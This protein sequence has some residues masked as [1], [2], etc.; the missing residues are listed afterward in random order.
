MRKS[1]EL[2]QGFKE[3]AG[4]LPQ[5]DFARYL[6]QTFDEQTAREVLKIFQQIELPAPE[7]EQEFLPGTEGCIAFLSRCG[8]SIRIEYKDMANSPSAHAAD[9]INDS[10]FIIRPLASIDAGKATIEI[11]PGCH[12]SDDG[13][14]SFRLSMQLH[15]L[16]INFWDEGPQNIGIIPV[17]TP[18]FPDGITVVIDRG[19]VNRL[20]TS[21]AQV[22][23]ALASAEASAAEEAEQELYAPLCQSFVE[24]WEGRQTMQ[25]FWDLCRIYAREGK[26]V[27]GWNEGEAG[28]PLMKKS[29]AADAAKSYEDRLQLADKPVSSTAPAVPRSQ[30]QPV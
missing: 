18:A 9:R 13:M 24:A 15:D 7:K 19:A 16:G 29:R 27:A 14:E 6:Q 8:V 21:V 30:R 11:C 1:A 20:T 28:N 22:K 23:K 2:E 4:V 17:K 26:L 25:Q 10:P 3:A 12:T 5:T